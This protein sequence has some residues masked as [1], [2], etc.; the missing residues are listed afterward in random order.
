M[1]KERALPC[2]LFRLYL[3]NLSGIA[4]KSLKISSTYRS[5]GDGTRGFRGDLDTGG[6]NVRIF[7]EGE[8][9]GRL[10]QEQ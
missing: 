2:I 7:L 6:Q 10:P 8:E 9:A 5:Q 4:R 3:L 1:P